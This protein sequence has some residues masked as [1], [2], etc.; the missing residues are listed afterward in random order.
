[1]LSQHGTQLV[2]TSDP[3]E[4]AHNTNAL[5][6]DTWV[7][8]GQEGEKIKRL[9]DFQGYQVTMQVMKN[10]ILFVLK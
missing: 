4:A 2:L 1:M 3:M 8:M 7:G 6:T 5:V 9:K 10:P